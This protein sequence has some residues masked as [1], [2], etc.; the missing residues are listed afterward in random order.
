MGTPVRKQRYFGIIHSLSALGYIFDGAK[1]TSGTS[2]DHA[3]L[4]QTQ[5]VH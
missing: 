2:P 5:I 4:N 1:P 3:A